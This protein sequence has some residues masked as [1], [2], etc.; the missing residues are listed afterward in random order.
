[1]SRHLTAAEVFLAIWT[2][3]TAWLPNESGGTKKSTRKPP[4]TMKIMVFIS[5]PPSSVDHFPGKRQHNER[6]N[7]FLLI[8]MTPGRINDAISFGFLVCFCPFCCHEHFNPMFYQRLM[9]HLFCIA[10]GIRTHSARKIKIIFLEQ[11]WK[12]SLVNMV[13]I[14]FQ[15][16]NELPRNIPPHLPFFPLKPVDW[17][18]GEDLCGAAQ[19]R[20]SA[21][22]GSCTFTEGK[23]WQGWFAHAANSLGGARAAWL[24]VFEHFGRLKCFLRWEGSWVW[25]GLT[26]KGPSEAGI[27]WFVR[28]LLFVPCMFLKANPRKGGDN[29]KI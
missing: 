20:S 18:Q 27:G 23:R 28:D 8:S 16:M 21:P 13:S 24:G 7:M 9:V 19:R 2:T 15:R 12:N 14:P 6:E 29:G 11:F 10:L 22:F 26:K 17:R 4:Q 3:Y 1:M 25:V 5:H